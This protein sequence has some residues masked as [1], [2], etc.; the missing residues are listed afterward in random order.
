MYI[1]TTILTQGG[2]WTAYTPVWSSSGT[3]PVLNNGVLVGSY[4][5]IGQTIIAR[6]NF[7]AGSSTTFGTGTWAF[8]LP[9][10]ENSTYGFAAGPGIA[11][12]SSLGQIFICHWRAT[13]VLSNA[14]PIV[15]F[16]PAVPFTWAQDDQLQ[17]EVLYQ[18]P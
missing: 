4:V 12:D 13:N 6:V 5:Q 7:V 11:F 10:A 14:S 3:Q 16:T 2:L 17:L 8:S 9:L 15:L 1:P 18:S